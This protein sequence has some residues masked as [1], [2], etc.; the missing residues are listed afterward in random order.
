[1]RIQKFIYSRNGRLLWGFLLLTLLTASCAKDTDDEWDPFYNWQARNAAWYEEIAD[2]A[3]TA[4]AGAKAQY[5]D[6]WA[7]HCAWRMY[8]SLQRSEHI[9][10][11]L[12]DSVC[13]HII[14]RGTGTVSPLFTDVANVSF[15]GWLM[16]TEYKGPHNTMIKSPAM[17]TQTFVGEYDPQTAIPQSMAVSSTVEGFGT[18]L[19]YMVT[20]DVWDVYIPQQLAY[21]E[22]SSSAIPAYS[23][24][25]FRIYLVE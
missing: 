9:G 16:S 17:F 13:V 1:M 20:G 12:E 3:R 15:Q 19:Q 14:Q 23:T 7:D 22:K 24:L 2:S 4:I 8:R 21:G 25:R 6:Q 11:P 10:G 5:G 18:A